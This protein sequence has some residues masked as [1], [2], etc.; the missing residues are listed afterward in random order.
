MGRYSRLQGGSW[1][2]EDKAS[3]NLKDS[4]ITVVLYAKLTLLGVPTCCS[5]IRLEACKR[6]RIAPPNFAN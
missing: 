6:P 5:W 3:E 4:Y 2:R 1:Q